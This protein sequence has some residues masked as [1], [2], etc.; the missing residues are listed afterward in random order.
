MCER[1][2]LLVDDHALYREAVACFLEGRP[3]LRLAGMARDGL[4]AL[5]QAARLRP[6]V[7]LI[8][9]SMPV[10]S[11]LEAIPMLRGLLP[12][13]YIIVLSLSGEH[14]YRDRALQAGADDYVA[15]EQAP[16]DLLPLLL[17]PSSAAGGYHV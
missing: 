11:G 12:R 4:E 9:L 15:K 8:D 7:I 5:E 10:C 2:I 17:Q 16:T 6:D 3:G 13:A 1:S 14:E